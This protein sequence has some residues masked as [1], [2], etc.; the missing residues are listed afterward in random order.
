MSGKAT[1]IMVTEKQKA[2]LEQIVNAATA[3][4][5]HAQRARIILEAFQE[6]LNRDIAAGVGLDRGQTGLWR[7]RW[8]D[9]FEALI[10]I[11][12]M[13][14]LVLPDRTNRGL[15]VFKPILTISARRCTLVQWRLGSAMHQLRSLYGMAGVPGSN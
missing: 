4:V 2:I 11:Y 6:K 15:R 14:V 3:T 10:A 8:A 1:R 5:R 7:R 12:T 9:S 13:P